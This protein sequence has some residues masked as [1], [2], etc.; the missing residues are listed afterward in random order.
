[1][2]CVTKVGCGSLNSSETSNGTGEPKCGSKSIIFIS[3]SIGGL[4]KYLYNKS[5]S[6]SS[7]STSCQGLIFGCNSLL[8]TIK[9]IDTG[10][11][12]I[13]GKVLVH[14]EPGAPATIISFS[15]TFA[16]SIEYPNCFPSPE[17]FQFLTVPVN[18]NGLFSSSKKVAVSVV[19]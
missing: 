7:S 16:V 10:V 5:L 13:G 14:F 8:N 15:P 17:F 2:C 19:K 12:A 6:F 3:N 4:E 18:G 11:E 1:M 9:P